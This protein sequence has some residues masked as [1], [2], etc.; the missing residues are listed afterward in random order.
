MSMLR[1]LRTVGKIAGGPLVHDPIAATNVI[2]LDFDESGRYQGAI[3]EA[4]QE[5]DVPR[6]LYK[7]AK[8]NNPPA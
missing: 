7:K 5:K 6:Y 2:A 8:G 1:A 3:L 4:F